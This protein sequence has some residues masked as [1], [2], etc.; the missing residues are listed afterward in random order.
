MK[1]CHVRFRGVTATAEL[2]RVIREHEGILQ[3]KLEPGERCESVLLECVDD[4]QVRVTLRLR[5]GATGD[6]HVYQYASDAL[7][8]VHQAFYQA[9][10][11]AQQQSPPSSGVRSARPGLR[12]TGGESFRR[13]GTA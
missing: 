1:A 6:M 3:Q 13:A 8:A 4:G 7:G 12:R 5:L 11:R 10:R 2:L 9:F